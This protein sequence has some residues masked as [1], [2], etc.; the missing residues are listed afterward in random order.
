M[1]R[2]Y[3]LNQA[4]IN[5]KIKAGRGKGAYSNYSPYVSVHDLS[6]K[7][8]S[9]RVL[10]WKTKRMYEFLSTLEFYF[11]LL[12]DWMDV[13]VDIQEQFLLQQSSTIEI[14]NAN[15]LRHPFYF[16]IENGKRVKQLSMMTVDFLIHTSE[17][18]VTQ[19]VARDIKYARDLTPHTLNKLEITRIYFKLLN[20]PYCV[21]TDRTMNLLL[22]NN[23]CWIHENYFWEEKI[24]IPFADAGHPIQLLSQLVYKNKLSVAQAGISIDSLFGFPKGEGV[25]ICH[26]LIARKLWKIDMAIPYHPRKSI[27]FLQ[28]PKELL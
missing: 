19:T 21:V 28:E 6:S 24:S 22:A 8:W 7:G 14:C 13:A 12:L 23:L 15:H 20:I 16:P 9:Y 17:K 1:R 18:G 4:A 5:R 25:N 3:N 26:Y 11:F 27:V 2:K 10:G